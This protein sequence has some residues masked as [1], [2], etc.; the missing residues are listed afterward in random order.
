M[1]AAYPIISQG[2]AAAIAG[3][4]RRDFLMALYLAKVEAS[5]VDIEEL[6]EEVERDLQARRGRLACERLGCTCPIRLKTSC[7]P[8]QG[9]N[10]DPV[11]VQPFFGTR[12]GFLSLIILGDLVNG[13]MS[14][15]W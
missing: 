14:A 10:S 11:A 4:S 3:L 6:K 9:S 1:I 8:Q 12:S 15:D 13:G 5:Q 7:S 2:K